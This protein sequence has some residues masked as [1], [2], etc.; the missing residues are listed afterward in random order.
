[1]VPAPA[2]LQ[3]RRRAGK[4]KQRW[5]ERRSSAIPRGSGDGTELEEE[6]EERPRA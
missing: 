1:M 3:L 6:E 4:R 5:A 2:N